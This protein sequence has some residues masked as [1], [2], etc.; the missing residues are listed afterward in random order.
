M[1]YLEYFVSGT[2]LQLVQ[3]QREPS[4]LQ[5]R[6]LYLCFP[7]FAEIPNYGLACHH[8]KSLR[9]RATEEATCESAQ[10]QIEER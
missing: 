10:N 7:P 9:Q 4:T 5:P 1:R 2:L 8:G 6:P 3:R